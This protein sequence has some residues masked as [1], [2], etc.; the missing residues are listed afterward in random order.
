MLCFFHLKKNPE[1]D[2]KK[3]FAFLGLFLMPCEEASLEL[4]PPPVTTRAPAWSKHQCAEN[5]R[6][7]K[8]KELA[9]TA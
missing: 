2:T 1:M 3:F 4:Q 8:W 6:A 7:E 9:L 5:G